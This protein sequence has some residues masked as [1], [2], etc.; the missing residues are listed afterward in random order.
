MKDR[1]IYFFP[2]SNALERGNYAVLNTHKC[3][4][5]QI[6]VNEEQNRFFTLGKN[7]DALIE[8]EVFDTKFHSKKG[9]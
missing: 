4:V 5:L 3:P 8:W 9:V 7:D 6:M 2:N 1:D